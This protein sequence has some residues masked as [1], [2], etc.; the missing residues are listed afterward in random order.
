MLKDLKVRE[1]TAKEARLLNP[2]Q[3]ALVGDYHKT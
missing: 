1:F 3:L 2:L